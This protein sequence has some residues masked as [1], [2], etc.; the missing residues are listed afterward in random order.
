[1]NILI[2]GLGSMGKRRIRNLKHLNVTTIEGFDLRQDRCEEA[3]ALYGIKTYSTIDGAL[4]NNKYDAFVISVPPH[5]HHIYMKLAVSL[6]MPFFVEASVVDDDMELIIKAVAENN[7]VAAPSS[8]MYFHPAIKKIRQILTDGDLGNLT[9]INYHSG[10]Y[11]PDWHTYEKVSEFYVSNKAT[12]GAR[13]IVPFELTWLVEL[14]GF[15]KKVTGMYKK[16]IHIEGAEE[17]D[18]TY[19]GLFDYGT[20]ILNLTVDVV[21][22][23][24]TRKLLINGAEGQLQWDWNDDYLLVYTP[25][26]GQVK[27]SFEMIEAQAGYNKNITEQM[28]IEEMAMFLEAVEG[29]IKFVNNL[30]QDH[31]VLKLLYLLEQAQDTQQIITL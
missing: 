8:T 28:Y 4:Q 24:A 10:Q 23:L 2:I 29:K 13:E 16:T 26:S 27:H 17:I 31:G 15:P 30:A 25:A 18:D 7:L 6:K 12:G 1:M 21:S 20:F 11:L 19:C 22:R 3:A 5:I 14:L 9:N